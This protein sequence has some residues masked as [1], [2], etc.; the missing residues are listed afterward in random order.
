LLA[1]V[2]MQ[3]NLSPKPASKTSAPT[4]K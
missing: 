3:A 2:M 1:Y 4:K